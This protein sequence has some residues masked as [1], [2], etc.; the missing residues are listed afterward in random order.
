MN[1]YKTHFLSL[2]GVGRSNTLVAS[3]PCCGKLRHGWRRKG[4]PVTAARNMHAR[5]CPDKK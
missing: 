3:M 1:R 2:H 4:T 5:H